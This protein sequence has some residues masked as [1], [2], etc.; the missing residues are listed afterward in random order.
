MLRRLSQVTR[1][2]ST[3]MLS[4]SAVRR[5]GSCAAIG[6]LLLTA[7]S[8]CSPPKLPLVAVAIDDQGHPTVV[9]YR[10]PDTRILSVEVFENLPVVTAEPGARQ[11]RIEGEAETD[12]EITMFTVP[13][14]WEPVELTLTTLA[15]GQDYAASAALSRS[16][17]MSVEF[18][19]SEMTQL[20]RG[21]VITYDVGQR[22]EA[23]MSRADFCAKAARACPR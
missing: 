3:P 8:A 18:T 2:A 12:V 10:C 20:T 13:E 19:V 6:V 16:F 4:W 1:R 14:G 15:D 5:L 22:H 11:W 9:V 21:T 23:V 7:L 17:A